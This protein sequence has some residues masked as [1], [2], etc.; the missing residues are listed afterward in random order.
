MVLSLI[1]CSM[2]AARLS[3]EP[4]F[5]PWNSD[6]LVGDEQK[7]QIPLLIL[8]AP[9]K[10][11]STVY[12]GPQGGAYSL[13]RFFQIFISP[14]DGPNCRFRPTCSAYG[15]KAVERFGALLGAILAGDRL[16][17]CNPYNPPGDD[18]VPSKLLDK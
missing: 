14:Q 13:I 1:L 18:P 2:S 3:A 5:Q 10:K 17:R 12:G 4:P 16:I 8:E 7:G 9:R 6:L 11:P 15:R